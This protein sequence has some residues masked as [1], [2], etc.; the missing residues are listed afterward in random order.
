[1]VKGSPYSLRSHLARLITLLIADELGNP[2]AS[3]WQ[4]H[5]RRALAAGQQQPERG[6]GKRLIAPGEDLPS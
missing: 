6:A 5:W 1:M 2:S 3:G 4:Q